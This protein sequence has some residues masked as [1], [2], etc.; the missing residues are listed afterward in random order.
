MKKLKIIGGV[1][2]HG[3][4]RVSGAKNAVLP[5][6]CATLLNP[7]KVTIKNIPDLADTRFLKSLLQELGVRIEG[8]SF[9]AE[10]ITSIEAPYEMVAQM[11][12]SILVLGPLL[13][14]FGEAKVNLPG[15]CAIGT[16]PVDLH[17][18]GMEKLGAKI[19]LENGMV[20]ATCKKLKGADITLK[21][22]SVGATENILMACVLAEGK[23]TIE[24]AAREPEIKDLADFLNAMGAKISGQGTSTITIEGVSTLHSAD[25]SVMGDRIEAITYLAA[26]IATRGTG[27]VVGFNPIDVQAVCDKFSQMGVSLKYEENAVEILR[28]PNS[29]LP[30]DITTL[31]HP[32]FP[33]DAQAQLMAL[34]TQA[35]GV[36]TVRETI[37]ENRFMHVSELL[38]FGAQIEIKGNTAFVHG[39]TNLTGAP[40]MASDLRASAALIIAALMAQGKST[41]HRLYHLDRGYEKLEFKL[42]ALGANVERIS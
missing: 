34:L 17:L 12:A 28:V 23:S 1:K 42:Q 33:T 29:F 35:K 5:I 26:I 14:R 24:N 22:P 32:G 30:V 21:F 20:H 27:K 13:A 8:E 16:R 7:Y 6:L 3:E 41:I 25:F 18:Y 37:F 11:R 40:V 36:S 31:P 39:P 10:K 19:E 38:R 9:C 15:G 2:L 4:V